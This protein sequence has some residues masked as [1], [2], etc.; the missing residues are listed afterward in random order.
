MATPP[1]IIDQVRKAIASTIEQNT[2]P[3]FKSNPYGPAKVNPP[4][5]FAGTHTAVPT[6]TD[7]GKAITFHWWVAVAANHI[8]KQRDL[9]EALL[10]V[11][12]AI[13]AN[14]DLGR[15]DLEI[16]AVWSEWGDHG[17][18]E[19]AGVAMW[20]ARLDIEVLLSGP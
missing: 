8:S 20:G 12:D 11:C 14:P 19:V 5:T 2:N 13:T 3:R 1:N 16:S 10:Q 4:C 7:G 9:D 15:D 17:D 18:L 6:D